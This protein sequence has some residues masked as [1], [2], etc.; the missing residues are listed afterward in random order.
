[1]NLVRLLVRGVLFIKTIDILSLFRKI[2]SR[3]SFFGNLSA[4][5]QAS[6]KVLYY[7]ISTITIVDFKMDQFPKPSIHSVDLRLYYLPGCINRFGLIALADFN[8]HS[9]KP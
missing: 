1:M 4:R 3:I 9:V 2:L 6:I 8:R 7:R 5:M